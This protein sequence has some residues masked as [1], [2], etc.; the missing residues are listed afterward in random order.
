MDVQGHNML[1]PSYVYKV[2]EE[3]Y[4]YWETVRVAKGMPTF[5]TYYKWDENLMFEIDRKGN[6]TPLLA[7][8]SIETSETFQSPLHEYNFPATPETHSRIVLYLKNI[9]NP[10]DLQN[11]L[12]IKP[13]TIGDWLRTGY[14][15]VYR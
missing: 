15:F 1:I 13:I 14:Y 7:H 2:R 5:L 6:Q 11:Y 9:N 3:N 12:R 10:Y 8:K 4:I